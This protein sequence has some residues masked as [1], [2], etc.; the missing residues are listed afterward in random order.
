MSWQW[1]RLLIVTCSNINEI[2]SEFLAKL[3]NYK[4]LESVDCDTNRNLLVQLL[5]TNGLLTISL[6]FR[7]I[8]KFRYFL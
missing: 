6:N 1:Q 3:K 5:K 4:K 2:I 7:V 8:E